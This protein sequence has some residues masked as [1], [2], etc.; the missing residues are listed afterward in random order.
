MPELLP[1]RLRRSLSSWSD[2]RRKASSCCRGEGSEEGG[3]SESRARH[4][5]RVRSSGEMR[6]GD[7]EED[8]PSGACA[9]VLVGKTT[10]IIAAILQACLAARLKI[11]HLDLDPALALV[12]VEA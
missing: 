1:V 2:F 9:P 6:T 3:P 10:S 7:M 5:S 11:L 12:L 4:R 8:N